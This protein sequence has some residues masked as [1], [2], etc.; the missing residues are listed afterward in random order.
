M[1]ETILEMCEAGQGKIASILK[2]EWL[3]F[4]TAGF[5]N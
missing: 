2:C 3:E 4:G 5:P 1:A